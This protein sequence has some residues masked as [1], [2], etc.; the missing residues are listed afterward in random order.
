MHIIKSEQ[1][2][3]NYVKRDEN[4]H[5]REEESTIETSKSAGAYK[6]QQAEQAK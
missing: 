2:V 1:A 5:H 3:A 6:K 4:L